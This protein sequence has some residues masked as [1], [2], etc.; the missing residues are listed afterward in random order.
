MMTLRVLQEEVKRR[1]F[2][3]GDSKFLAGGMSAEAGEAFGAIKN[4]LRADSGCYV[5]KIAKFDA[6]DERAELADELADVMFYAAAIANYFHWDLASVF[7]EKMAKNDRKYSRKPTERCLACGLDV[8]EHVGP[9]GPHPDECAARLKC[10]PGRDRH[11]NDFFSGDNCFYCGKR[12][13]HK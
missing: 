11:C 10:I 5:G 7:T 8:N 2:E 4:M 12:G 9:D 13:P 3:Q 6:N 1:Y